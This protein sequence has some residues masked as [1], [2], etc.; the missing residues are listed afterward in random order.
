MLAIIRALVLT[1]IAAA[2]ALVVGANLGAA[3]GHGIAVI[4]KRDPAE[5]KDMMI[6]CMIGT[7]L[8]TTSGTIWAMTIVLKASRL[9]KIAAGALFCLLTLA[10]ISI[11]TI[12]YIEAPRY[13]SQR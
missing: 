13:A 10:S 12:A 3:L 8:V 1:V 5:L 11:T 2:V 6:W 4:T 9:I 7:T